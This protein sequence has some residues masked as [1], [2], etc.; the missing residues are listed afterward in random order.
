MIVKA[1]HAYERS[2]NVLYFLFYKSTLLGLQLF[3]FN[4]YCSYTGTTLFDSLFIFFY[5]FLFSIPNV[6]VIGLLD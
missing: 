2:L 4:W 3:Y 6:I 5:N 1:R